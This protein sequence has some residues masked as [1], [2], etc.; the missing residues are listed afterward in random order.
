M[1][2]FLC[3][4]AYW[5]T[6]G[7]FAQTNEYVSVV[8]E[9]GDKLT[10]MAQRYLMPSSSHDWLSLA[11]F[12]KLSKPYIVRTGSEL[13]LPLGLF[14]AQTAP[15]QWLA[16]TG[17]VRV[18]RSADTLGVLAVV[19]S[20]FLEGDMVKVGLDSSAV[21]ALA[22][23]TQVK[24]L[25]DTQLALGE[26]RYYLPQA[27]SASPVVL[28]GAK[29]FS[30]LMRLIQGSVETRAIP[31]ND[32]ARPLRIQTPTSVVGVRGTD[33]RVSHVGDTRSEVTQ[34]LV[35]AQL[36]ESRKTDVAAGF[37]VKLD[38]GQNK[39]PEVVPLLDAPNVT[40]WSQ[41]YE[42]LTVE[43]PAMPSVQ[44]GRKVTAY[45]L[46]V[47]SD[48]PMTK[49]VFGKLFAADKSLR[50]P[51]LPDG[52]WYARLRAVDEQGIEGNNANFTFTLKARPQPPL[53]QTPKPNAKFVLSEG[54]PFGWAKMIGASQYRVEIQNEQQLPY[55]TY[56]T[57][58]TKWLMNDLPVGSYR[59]R[60]ATEVKKSDGTMDRGPWSEFQAFKVIATPVP[61]EGKL[62]E[63]AKALGLRWEDQKAQEYEVQ[64]A[65]EPTFDPLKS[66]ILTKKVV[67]PQSIVPNPETG[68]H[69]IRYRAIEDDGF[70]SSWSST[71]EVEVPVDWRPLWLFLGGVLLVF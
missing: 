25:E 49:I 14:Q 48:E 61:A 62:D 9:R 50:V 34:G 24:L 27:Q 47:A 21:L 59:W 1:R 55:K 3:L 41:K 29:A 7:V 17:D 13:R 44:G 20:P 37:G 28:S 57:T 52:V 8:V 10:T 51:D 45:R 22:D 32:R 63:N 71:M 2:S 16:V 60:I 36:D 30:G 23:G 68:K 54:V 58:D 66:P 15:A 38:P 12:N 11:R 19:G 4:F 65:R 18:G 43:F 35:Q 39:I 5:L 33:F 53:V 6:A 46:Q 64:V 70:V 42:K 31:A 69:F 56:D 26:S 40:S 67:D